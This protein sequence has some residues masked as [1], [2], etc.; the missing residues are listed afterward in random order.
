MTDEELQ[1]LWA[2]DFRLFGGSL[3]DERSVQGSHNAKKRRGRGFTGKKIGT[4][5]YDKK[6]GEINVNTDD[7]EAR[8]NES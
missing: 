1:S 4:I 3:N 7:P 2:S 6:T 8:A 5:E